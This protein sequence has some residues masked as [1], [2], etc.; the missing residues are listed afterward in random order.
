MKLCQMEQW[1][2]FVVV[3]VQVYAACC[4]GASST[5]TTLS[6]CDYASENLHVVNASAPGALFPTG[7]VECSNATGSDLELC[8]VCSCRERE[9]ASVAGVT[10]AWVVCVGSGDATACAGSAGSE[11]EFCGNRS[12]SYSQDSSSVSAGLSVNVGDSSS[13]TSSDVGDA[14]AGVI[15]TSGSFSSSS[16]SSSADTGVDIGS[17]SSF[18]TISSSV[19]SSFS[20]DEGTSSTPNP[21]SVESLTIYPEVSQS[22]ASNEDNV[23]TNIAG[24]VAPSQ[25]SAATASQE[26]SI[27]PSDNGSTQQLE[28]NSG[29]SKSSGW[30]GKRLTVI[31][32]VMCGVVAVAAIA[33]F[34]A[35]RNDRARKRKTL[36]TPSGDFTDDGSSVATPVT[37]RLDGRYRHHGHSRRHGG[38][39]GHN[40][41]SAGA[42]FDSSD[43]TPLASIVVLDLDDDFN[44]PA[45]YASRNQHRSRKD[46]GRKLS[47]GYVRT[48]SVKAG[49]GNVRLDNAQTSF[50]VP[51][52]NASR[53]PSV[54]ELSSP[55][56]NPIYDTS[57]TQVSYSSS[58]SS[59]Y[60][61]PPSPRV[62]ESE[63]IAAGS[64]R[65]VSA[66]YSDSVRDSDAS[67]IPRER[68][69][70]NDIAEEGDDALNTIV[71][72]ASSLSSL[73]ST[74]Y[75]LRSTEASEHM[76]PSELPSRSALSFDVGSNY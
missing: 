63:D 38:H 48:E 51:M 68:Y 31:V 8:A 1:C 50:P 29:A 52:F 53:G 4:F 6:A 21:T 9:V 33:V 43:N 30:S 24:T 57:N 35:V 19:G 74:Q 32:S 59:Q 36:G 20:S 47:G 73:D 62:Y 58:M 45:S 2:L 7:Y 17:S 70:T 65:L 23:I 12:G 27:R 75:E 13:S 5:D 76:H 25:T 61:S 41:G 42:M 71:S 40:H 26:N 56:H 28:T 44:A 16:S 46:Q 14:S 34:V 15:P 10:V 55:S 37:S 60:D 11:Q 69:T 22:R 39:H 67:T 64:I 66:T 3:I 72:F 54:S 49:E 18:D